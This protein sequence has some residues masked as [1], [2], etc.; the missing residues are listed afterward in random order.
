MTLDGIGA[1]F[2]AR[3]NPQAWRLI[4][5]L[6]LVVWAFIKLLISSVCFAQAWRLFCD[7]GVFATLTAFGPLVCGG[8]CCY[9]AW[10]DYRALKDS[11][12]AVTLRWYVQDYSRTVIAG[13]QGA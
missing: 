11:R 7:S 4:S 12:V 6:Q 2:L 13:T 1:A 9:L 8:R 10:S 3:R 5:S